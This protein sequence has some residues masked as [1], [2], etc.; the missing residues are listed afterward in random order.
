VK[1]SNIDFHNEVIQRVPKNI[2]N[3]NF[4]QY[5]KS[6][7]MKDNIV[8]SNP[9]L[10]TSQKDKKKA[11]LGAYTKIHNT[12]T[13]TNSNNQ[14]HNIKNYADKV[15]YNNTNNSNNNLKNLSLHSNN[16]SHIQKN[17]LKYNFKKNSKINNYLTPHN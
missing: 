6:Q 1:H 4:A 10:T 7:E 14:P 13:N 8:L 3:S 5:E 17:D 2:I 15:V 12:N 11:F 9:L 16:E